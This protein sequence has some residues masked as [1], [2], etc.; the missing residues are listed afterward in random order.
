MLGTHAPTNN[1]MR[2]KEVIPLGGAAEIVFEAG[3]KIPY[4][5]GDRLMVY[6]QNSPEHVRE[7][8]AA[9]GRPLNTPVAL[10]SPAW[11]QAVTRRGVVPVRGPGGEISISLRT[12]LSLASRARR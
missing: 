9:L 4:Q 1:L 10:L 5:P 12:L 2:V 11:Q 8:A 3:G 6:A 7:V